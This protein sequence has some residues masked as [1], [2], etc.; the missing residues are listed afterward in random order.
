[1]APIME[2]KKW[3]REVTE[4][5]LWIDSAHQAAVYHTHDYDWRS[6]RRRCLS[7]GYGWRL[8]GER[9]GFTDMVRDMSKPGVYGELAR[10]VVSGKVRKP[11]ALF[12]PWVRPWMLWVGNR[13]S[14]DVQL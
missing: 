7:E 1:W 5:G 3:Q 6:L 12:F 13:W 14:R 11:A 4:A 9:Y 2:D 10:G 8:L